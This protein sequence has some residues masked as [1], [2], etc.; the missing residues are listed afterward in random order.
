MRHPQGVSASSLLQ[1]YLITANLRGTWPSG[2]PSERRGFP[3]GNP[4]T[5]YSAARACNELGFAAETMKS[6]IRGTISDLKR[7]PLNT[8]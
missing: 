6:W 3:A 1:S 7:D 8:P 2:G 5:L 4:K